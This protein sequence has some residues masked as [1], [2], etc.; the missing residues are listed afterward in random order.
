MEAA[1]RTVNVELRNIARRVMLQR[2]RS[3][4]CLYAD[5]APDATMPDIARKPLS[6]IAL[7][8]QIRPEAVHDR[9]E[10]R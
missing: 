4:R 10:P 9:N 3:V 8:R 2:R 6:E 7:F 5:P 1:A